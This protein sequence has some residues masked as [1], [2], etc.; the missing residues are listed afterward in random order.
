M[1]LLRCGAVSDPVSHV[2]LPAILLATFLVSFPVAHRACG[3]QTAAPEAASADAADERSSQENLLR[4]MTTEGIELTNDKSFVLPEPSFVSV[5]GEPADSPSAMKALETLAG[6]HG[7]SRF[8]RDSV[9]APISVQTDSIKNDEGD[10]IGHFIDVAFVVHQS[11][12]EIRKSEALEDFKSDPDSPEK[13]IELSDQDNPEELE[14]NKTRSLTKQ[15]LADFNV[16]LDG[17]YEALG[18]LQMPLLSKV[19]VRG[20]ARARRSIWSTDDETA[21]IILTW[22]LDSRF[23]SP[24]PDPESISNQWRAIERNSVGEKELGPPHP[25][26]GM[27]GYVAI[28]PV[29][30][31]EQASIIQLRFVLH[32]PHDWFD[33]RN[34][35]RSKL[36][37]LIQDRVR[38]LRRELQD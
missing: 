8:T 11:I 38:N 28:T 36:P 32:E 20:V 12:A 30:G 33:G 23:G 15:E 22:L 27:G 4:K 21:P 29:P 6:R 35:L 5:T 16:T 18:Y 7:V 17:Q 37:I 34:L 31:Q 3:E 26:A 24:T 9:V 19:V 2:T 13:T 25:Y 10:R 14:K 1:N